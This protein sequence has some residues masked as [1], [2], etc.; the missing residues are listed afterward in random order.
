MIFLYYF[1]K[2][3]G[4]C[5]LTL[6]EHWKCSPI[7][8]FYSILLSLLFFLLF[9]NAIFLRSKYLSSNEPQ[10]SFIVDLFVFLLQFLTAISC[11]LLFALR[12]KKL[13][14]IINS[15][16]NINKVAVKFGVLKVNET[17][18]KKI[19]EE[20]NKK[21]NTTVID[22]NIVHYV[23]I[24]NIYDFSIHLFNQLMYSKFSSYNILWPW[25]DLIYIL[26]TNVFLY[27]VIFLY[28]LQRRFYFLNVQLGKLMRN[29][30]FESDLEKSR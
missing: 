29:N 9:L 7:S 15:L 1:A 24:V 11:W 5:P 19:N 28:S 12:Q 13:L 6:D 4:L 25:F 2:I 18:N 17:I 14:N 21:I 23:L 22:N 3:I 10:V 8:I 27:F 30:Q 16:E 26:G 20:I